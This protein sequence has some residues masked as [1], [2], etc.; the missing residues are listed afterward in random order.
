MRRLLH[1]GPVRALDQALRRALD[2]PKPVARSVPRQSPVLGVPA[3][4]DPAAFPAL[5]K[6]AAA[7][8]PYLPPDG[9]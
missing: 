4:A 2:V 3:L 5:D 1:T 9:C 6:V 8:I 7:A